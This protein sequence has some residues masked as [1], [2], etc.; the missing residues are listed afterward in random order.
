MLDVL[1]AGGLD[2][3]WD[4]GIFDFL[5]SLENVWLLINCVCVAGNNVLEVGAALDWDARPLGYCL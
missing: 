2:S 3:P 4:D 5:G 1:E